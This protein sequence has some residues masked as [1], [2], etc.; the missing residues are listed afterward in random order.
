MRSP[1]TA[2]ARLVGA[3]ATAAVVVPLMSG[4]QTNAGSAAFVGKDKISTVDLTAMAQRSQQALAA[5]GSAQAA[6]PEA[7][8]RNDLSLLITDKLLQR[9]GA[10][11]GVT[12]SNTDV[13]TFQSQQLAANGEALTQQ[14]A[15]QGI[16]Q[17]DQKLLFRVQLLDTRIGAKLGAS[18]KQQSDPVVP[19]IVQESKRVG[20]R[21]NPRF[22]T[23]DAANVR[24]RP[25][26]DDLSS[27]ASPANAAVPST[28]P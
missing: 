9:V 7:V 2:R 17:A 22:G 21:V 25:P 10:A 15:S 18:P 8:Q 24:V 14:L 26:A 6:T 27:P 19:L 1:R 16:G 20:V 5:A 28:A 12:V 3:A 13:Q 4:C 23:W 11:K